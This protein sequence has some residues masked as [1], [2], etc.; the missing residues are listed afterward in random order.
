MFD[1]AGY[2]TAAVSNNTWISEEFGFS[3]GFDTFHKTWQYVQS[4]TDLG[5]IARTK[6]G[7]EMFRALA[8]RLTDGNPVVNV[9]NAVYG[10]FLR[11]QKDDGAKQTNEWIAN[12]LTE[13]SGDDPF[14]L[15]ANYLEPH[16]E[17]RPPKQYAERFLPDDVSFEAAMD[18]SQDAWGYIAGEVSL[19]DHEFEILRALYHAEIAYL[20]ERIGELRDLL[21][22]A[23]E[24]DDTIFVVTSDH[25]ENIGEHGMM[26]HQYCLY[27]T[28]THVPLIIHGDGF[29]QGTTN[30]D[31]IQL[32]DLVPTLLDAAGIDDSAM[33]SQIQGR[34]FHPESEAPTR[35]YLISEYMAPQPSM[36]A[37]KKRVGTLTDE[38]QR[39]DRSLRSIRTKEHKLI[40]GSDGSRE[41][42]HV[43]NDPA[44]QEDLAGRVEQ[45]ADELEDELEEWLASFEHAETDGTVSMSNDAKSRLEDLGYLQ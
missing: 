22:E 1:D 32:T 31:L 21:I 9:A 43:A 41:F 33:Q 24:W 7:M 15:F 36:D 37:L 40:V 3:R 35:E 23:G 18:V 42:Y 29:G 20:D 17:Y 26:D 44:E 13:R 11:K 5:E 25:G 19:S 16:L 38:L 12:W 39:Y 34:S 4:D 8:S 6:E 10:K 27:D 28:L 2:E 30:D 14:F 45:R